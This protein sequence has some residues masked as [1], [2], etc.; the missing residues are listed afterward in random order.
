MGCHGSMVEHT[1]SSRKSRVRFQ[2]LSTSNANKSSKLLLTQM[3]EANVGWAYVKTSQYSRNIGATK[4]V[5]HVK[6]SYT[7]VTRGPLKRGQP[8]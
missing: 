1:T 5:L 6:A 3:G 2:F 4:T 8:S 7:A